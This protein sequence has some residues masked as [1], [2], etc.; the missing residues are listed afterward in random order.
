MRLIIQCFCLLIFIFIDGCKYEHNPIGSLYR[1]LIID[2]RPNT[3]KDC[4][5]DVLMLGDINGDGYSDVIAGANYYHNVQANE[6]AAFI[7]YGSSTGTTTTGALMLEINIAS[8]YFGDAVGAAGD[9]NGDGYS[10]VIVGAERFTNGQTEEGAFWIYHGSATGLTTT[11]AAKVE[12]NQASNHLGISVN[13]AG[14]VNGDGYSDVIVGQYA[15]TNGQTYEG[16]AFVYHGSSGGI[17]TTPVTTLE[18]N[19]AGAYFGFSVNSAGDVNGDGYSDVVVGA[20]NYNNGES[21]EGAVFIYHGSSSGIS[22]TVAMMAESNNAGWNLGRSVAC[23]GDVNGDSYSDVIAGARS[24][25]NNQASEGAAFVYYGNAGSTGRRNNVRLYNTDLSTPIQQSNKPNTAFGLGLYATSPQGKQKVKMM[26]EVKQQGQAFSSAGGK[27]TNSVSST[28]SQGSFSN[29][30]LT[31]TNLT[32]SVTKPGMHTKVRCRV[33]YDLVTSVTGQKYGPWRYPQGYF[34]GAHGMSSTPLPVE[35]L[36]FTAQ[37]IQEG[38]TARL[39]WSTASEKN[40]SHFTILRSTDGQ[41]W[42]EIN[43]VTGAGT[44]NTASA[45]QYIDHTLSHINTSTHQQVYYRIMQTDFNGQFSLSDMRE[46]KIEL[47]T[48]ISVSPNPG[49]TQVIT[50]QQAAPVDLPYTIVDMQGKEV[51]SG[52]ILKGNTQQAIS[53]QQLPAGVYLLSIEQ[54]GITERIKLIRQ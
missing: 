2:P 32:S 31:G 37:W 23:G 8:S 27:I 49:A 50:L 6:G 53:L 10:D 11:A 44:T 24:Y 16:V 21:G 52:I 28:S 43:M 26:W 48:K 17:N 33:Q 41:T 46:L 39:N 12:S 4:C 18:C 3:G 1:H 13:S 36:N 45:Y 22:T 54:A 15:Y 42:E 7:Y 38:V 51:S 40:N 5:T 25:T 47:Q 30:G 29:S 9:V 19:V 34:S 20:Y 35:W 14:D